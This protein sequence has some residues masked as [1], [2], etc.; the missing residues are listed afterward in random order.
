MLIT[1]AASAVEPSPLGSMAKS[2][3]WISAT[4]RAGGA[5]RR[6]DLDRQQL[7]VGGDALGA[8]D[9][10]G[11]VRAVGAVAD[12][13]DRARTARDRVGIG[14]QRRAARATDPHLAHEVVAADD[15]GR[16]EQLGPLVGVVDLL[17]LRVLEL[18][19]VGVLVGQRGPRSAERGMGVVDPRVE[20]GDRDARAGDAQ[21]LD[22]GPADVRHRL[23]E[24][25]LVID[26]RVDRQH[27]R[28]SRQP[29]EMLRI[30]RRHDRVERD[31]GPA[32]DLE[33]AID[34][35]GPD[36][37]VPLLPIDPAQL[38]PLL[39]GTLH[40][41]GRNALEADDDLLLP[42]RVAQRGGEDDRPDAV[43]RGDLAALDPEVLGRLRQLPLRRVGGTDG[44]RD[45]GAQEHGGPDQ[46]RTQ[47][48]TIHLLPFRLTP[49]SRWGVG[50]GACA[51]GRV[52]DA[53]PD[54][55]PGHGSRPS[56]ADP[57]ARTVL[58]RS[59]KGQRD[60]DGAP[61][62]RCARAPRS[63][64]GNRDAPGRR[65]GAS[66]DWSVT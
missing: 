27:G 29:G 3:P 12:L 49:D 42:L 51:R 6:A 56:P 55:P 1:L 9:D 61:G 36:L 35:R 34:G 57:D 2:M 23:V 33:R 44:R 16:R 26:H 8:G 17:V 59:C 19:P 62:R 53:W 66:P 13:L 14:R 20:D 64:H 39:R 4:P 60:S 10:V 11:H 25:Q 45:D 65:P 63:Q 24:V 28:I 41:R 52:Q 47:P 32:Q 48:P 18:G 15:L 5:E 54:P 22:G 38:G 37:E 7:R 21:L 43:G 31:L 58:P 30:D 46:G 50:G 40:P